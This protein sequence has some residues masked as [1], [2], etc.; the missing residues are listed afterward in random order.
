[1]TFSAKKI[2]QIFAILFVFLFIIASN[3]SRNYLLNISNNV[4][5]QSKYTQSMFYLKEVK[6]NTIQVQQ[7][8]TDVSATHDAAGYDEAQKQYDNS[9]QNLNDFLQM[10]PKYR[11]Q[12]KVIKKDIDDFYKR[13]R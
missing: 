7:F 13:A 3:I 4:L 9:K 11:S 1:M 6:F 12:V 5:L 10:Q 2:I 8:L